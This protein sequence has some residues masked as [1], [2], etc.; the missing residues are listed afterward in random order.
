[1]ATDVTRRTE[2]QGDSSVP[3]D[4]TKLTATIHFRLS[5]A[6]QKAALLAGRNAEADQAL[7]YELPADAL[8]LLSISSTGILSADA[9]DGYAKHFDAIPTADEIVAYLRAEQAERAEQ[10]AR[11]KEEMLRGAEQ[12]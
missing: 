11:S 2:T 4:T 7:D 8:D 1:M 12:D 9:R 5:S 3:Q 6:G 10:A